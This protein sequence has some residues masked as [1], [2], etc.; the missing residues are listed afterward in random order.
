[1][2]EVEKHANYVGSHTDRAVMA[3]QEQ[4]SDSL[5]VGINCDYHEFIALV[6]YLIWNVHEKGAPLEKIGEDLNKAIK[7]LKEMQGGENE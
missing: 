4:D 1:M 7:L 5:T 2:T 3:Y 6:A